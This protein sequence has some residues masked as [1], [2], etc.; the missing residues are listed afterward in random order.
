[1]FADGH[2]GVEKIR[3]DLEA[4]HLRHVREALDTN[5]DASRVSARGGPVEALRAPDERGPVLG[6]S[7]STELFDREELD[8]LDDLDDVDVLPADQDRV[9]GRAVR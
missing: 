9:P 6:T 3:I 8:L 2:G 1:V 7:A 5:P 4:P